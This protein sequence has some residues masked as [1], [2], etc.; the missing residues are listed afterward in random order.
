[1]AAASPNSTASL[2]RTLTRANEL[3]S[4][5]PRKKMATAASRTA[6]PAHAGYGALVELPAV[7]LVNEI[8]SEFGAQ[9][10]LYEQGRKGR[11]KNGEK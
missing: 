2:C 7:R 10:E 9:R 6:E 4:K 5:K 11:R 1:M 8:Q 3:S